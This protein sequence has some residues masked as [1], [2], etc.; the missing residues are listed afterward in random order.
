LIFV[1][2]LPSPKF[3]RYPEPGNPAIESLVKST[4]AGTQ[5]SAYSG[6]KLTTGTGFTIMLVVV[7]TGGLHPSS[8]VTV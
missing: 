5:L 7:C 8:I 6:V 2:V 4:E 3:Q 1:D